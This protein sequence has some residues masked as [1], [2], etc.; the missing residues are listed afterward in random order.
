MDALHELL[1]TARDRLWCVQPHC[2]TCGARDYR[3]AIRDNAVA[4]VEA[5]KTTRIGELEHECPDIRIDDALRLLFMELANPFGP[6]L[7][8]TMTADA[9]L[10][11][12]EA[13][14]YLTRMRRHEERLI[15]DRAEAE[16]QALVER[17]AARV[18][19]SLERQGLLVRDTEDD[20]LEFG[21]AAG[22]AM[23]DLIGHSITYRV[24]VGPRAG[25]KVFTLQTVPAR[26]VEPRPGVAQY[27]GFSLHAGIG[28]EA[29]QRAK[30]ERLARY[31]S[32]PPV[33]VE[34]L[35]LTAQGQVRYRLKTPYRDG[36]THIVLEPVDFM[37]RL[38][39]LVPP[40]RAHLTRYHGSVGQRGQQHGGADA[41]LASH[42]GEHQAAKER[43]L[44][45]ADRKA[46]DESRQQ[47]HCD[48]RGI[49]PRPRNPK[50]QGQH[51]ERHRQHHC[52]AE[53][54]RATRLPQEA[55]AGQVPAPIGALEQPQP[56]DAQ[57]HADQHRRLPDT[58][59]DP[60]ERPVRLQRMQDQVQRVDE[61]G[62]QHQ[63]AGNRH[64]EPAECAHRKRP[65]PRRGPGVRYWCAHAE[66]IDKVGALAGRLTYGADAAKSVKHFEQA[67]KLNPGSAIAHMEYANG[68]LMLHG[69]AKKKQAIELYRK[70]AACKPA[71]AMERLDVEQAKVELE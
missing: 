17:L 15:E 53:R 1:T 35:A 30:L 66:I 28:V 61:H 54:E 37:A 4:L 62:C 59:G 14:E 16:L 12:T 48:R 52:E 39:A 25:Q 3:Q 20:F 38:A 13:G 63:R 23:D 9:E 69:D 33:S 51:C 56:P 65:R 42:R 68:L 60:V 31:V 22:G 8:V 55:G 32:R 21:P 50:P 5:L 24:A 27:A 58:A 67:L 29:D 40:P 7:G 10:A 44:Q 57:R 45:Q 36:T 18:G 71:D 11:G 34:R 19:R 46:R 43:F 64:Q 49:E 26:G 6:L 47:R 2:T 41:R 70:A